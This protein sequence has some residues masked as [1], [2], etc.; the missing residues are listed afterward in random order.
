MR[1]KKE[2]LQHIKTGYIPSVQELTALL[3]DD[4]GDLMMYLFKIADKVTKELFRNEIHIRG[5]IEFSNYCRCD[6][7]YCGLNCKNKRIKRYRMMP[8][9][10][11][12]TA[13]EAI[14]AGYKT[15]VLQSG[16][17][18]WYT[19]EK[20]SW[21]IKEIKALGDIAITLSVGEREFDDF[22]HWRKVGAD[23]FLLK[24]ETSNK[25]LFKKLHPSR[26][27]NQRLKCLKE[28]NKLNYQV[29]SGFMIGLPGQTLADI[30][31][32]ILLLKKFDVDMAGIG[33]FIPHNDT[34][35]SRCHSGDS[36]LTL[37]TLALTRLLLKD[38]HLPATTALIT[39]GK[40]FLKQA[41]FAGANVVML[42]LEPYKYRK[43]YEIYPKESGQEMS[44]KE[45]RETMEKYLNSLN[46]KV[47]NERGDSPKS[48]RRLKNERYKSK[49]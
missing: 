48:L 42:K 44:I 20:I 1:K 45:E 33:P 30:S 35:L 47:S 38:A 14:E 26:R 25:T 4:D 3:K 16:E 41:F 15:L 28:L 31:K 32:D 7:I 46:L 18:L 23:R 21:I 12:D 19:C 24:H 34:L 2:L 39:K 43:L 8:E 17:D 40:N 10:I 36:I 37:K 49:G 29:G 22:K 27:L 11:I 6:C 13:T 9:E 5:I